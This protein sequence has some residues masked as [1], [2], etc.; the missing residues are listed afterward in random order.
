MVITGLLLLF[1]GAS[2]GYMVMG[3]GKGDRATPAG[4]TVSAGEQGHKV[5]AYYFH[6]NARCRT[7]KSIE[8][9]TLEVLQTSFPEALDAGDLVWKPVNIDQAENEHFVDDFQL[10]SRIVVIADMVDGKAVKWTNLDRVWELVG[11]PEAFEE[12]IRSSA[13]EYLEGLR[14]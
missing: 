13:A 12:Y 6:G 9:G 2:V 5:V 8:A 4:E 11:D 10:P 7:C 3:N 1:V 14:G